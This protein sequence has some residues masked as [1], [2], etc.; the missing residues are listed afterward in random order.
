[1]RQVLRNEQ[2]IHRH[3]VCLYGDDARFLALAAMTLRMSVSELIRIALWLYLPRLALGIHN[4]K[5]VSDAALFWRGIKQWL[6]I[7]LT[8]NNLMRTPAIRRCT[9][10]SFLPAHWW[11]KGHTPADHGAGDMRFFATA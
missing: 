5:Y 2:T 10:A 11:P 6:A 9:F 3:V 1:M 8:G 7:S 4:R